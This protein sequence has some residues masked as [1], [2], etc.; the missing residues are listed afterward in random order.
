MELKRMVTNRTPIS[1][2]S[3]RL[4]IPEHMN[5][6]LGPSPRRPAVFASDA[7]RR[8]VWMQHR[9][10]L[11]GQCTGT[12]PDAWWCYDAPIPYPKDRQYEEATLF[13]A[14]LL[15]PDE[16][17]PVMMR[18]RAHFDDAQVP[19][20]FYCTGDGWLRGAEAREAQYKWAGIPRK[21]LVQWRA[22]RRKAKRTAAS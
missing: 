9:D 3:R 18:W 21:L 14:G 13:E 20:F 12:R 2:R 15:A 10:E 19:D 6:T 22:E 11:I 7:E 1:R 5:L 17:A 8:A 16:I 4:S